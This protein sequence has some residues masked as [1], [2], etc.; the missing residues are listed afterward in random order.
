MRCVNIDWLEVY[1]LEF[2]DEVHPRDYGPAYFE[3]LGYKVIV[4]D[5]GTPQYK[6]MFTIYGSDNREFVEIRRQPYSVKSEGGIFPDNACHV[7][8]SN[9]SCYAPNCIDSLRKFL[10]AFNYTLCGISR[11]DICADFNEFDDD[12]DPAAFV[13][14]Y[15]SGQLHKLGLSR[16]HAYGLDYDKTNLVV[17][18][19]RGK[20]VKNPKIMYHGHVVAVHGKDGLFE[21]RFNSIKWGAP[22][23]R[24]SVKLYDKSMEMKEVRT[25]FYIQDAWKAAKL[26]TAKPVWRLE[27]SVASDAKNWLNSETGEVV[28]LSLTTIDSP[29]KLNRFFNVLAARYFRFTRQINT[30]KGTPM[31]KDRCPAINPVDTSKVDVFKPVALPK[32]TEPNRT[33]KM[34]VK[35]L[36]KIVH[37]KQNA[38]LREREAARC[39]L[40]YFN[41]NMR[42]N[43]KNVANL[44]TFYDKTEPHNAVQH[45]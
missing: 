26:D 20:L 4:R 33:D 41:R 14:R 16:V 1:C 45:D 28:E 39:V 44:F 8:L 15:M 35:R 23:S 22:S 34:L 5:Y 3:K 30:R 42:F 31:R 9:R 17:Q 25:K 36:E 32:E 13:R 27:F 40:E 29:D 12:T 19:E 2:I 38:L 6:Q 43:S 11:V 10:I 37:D 24:V 21:H 7:R 18:D